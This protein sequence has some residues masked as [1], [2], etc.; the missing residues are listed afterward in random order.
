MELKPRCAS[1]VRY[2]SV[3]A[4]SAAFTLAGCAGGDRGEDATPEPWSTPADAHEAA[5]GLAPAP[6]ANPLAGTRWRLVQ[7]QSMDDVVGTIH[8]E[9]P[10]AFTMT[11]NADGTV[12]LRLDCNRANGAYTVEPAADPE[13]G[14]FEFGPL[15]ATRARCPLPRLDE[16]IVAQTQYIRGYLIRDGKLYLSLMADG[17]IWA[18]ES[19]AE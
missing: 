3:V 10:S 7:I 2:A 8:L 9:N 18:W 6:S 14:R 19:D 17:G 4:I 15:V 16:Q 13:N 11:L 12:N 5:A 1:S